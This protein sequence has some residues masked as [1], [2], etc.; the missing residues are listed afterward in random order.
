[1]V[2]TIYYESYLL[3]IFLHSISNPAPPKPL[4]HYRSLAELIGPR[5]IDHSVS[6]CSRSEYYVGCNDGDSRCEWVDCCAW[7]ELN[8]CFLYCFS[9]PSAERW[10]RRTLVQRHWQATLFLGWSH[11]RLAKVE[12][13]RGLCINVTIYFNFTFMPL[14]L[15]IV[16]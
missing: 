9:F 8:Y 12:E 13:N 7:L 15:V 1:M 4:P 10:S 11:S 3:T 14:W 6:A 16:K 5:F 2:W